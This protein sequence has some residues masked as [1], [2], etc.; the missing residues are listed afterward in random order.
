MDI[1]RLDT[2]DDNFDAALRELLTREAVS[3]AAVFATVDDVLQQVRSRGDTA[4][5][6]FTARFDRVEAQSA[7]ELEMPIERLRQAFE[8][9]D[10]RERSALQQAAARIRSYAEHQKLESWS[11][12]ETDGTLLVRSIASGYT[13]P[14]ARRLIRR[15]Y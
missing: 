9:L 15:R 2:R 10:A 3:D 14:A 11:Y 13:C 5:L 8:G 4:L 6:E 7:A 1:R 12:T